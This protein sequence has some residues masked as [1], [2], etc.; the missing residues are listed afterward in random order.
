MSLR[1]EIF[2]HA[3]TDLARQYDWYFEHAGLEIAE[4]YLK[5]FDATVTTLVFHPGLG[6]L[7][8]FR[9]PSL[10]GIRAHPFKTPL[11]SI[12]FFIGRI[13]RR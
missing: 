8:K 11:I 2:P 9:A 10:A 6:R 5:A 4:R 7:R 13:L 12:L 1:V 3:E